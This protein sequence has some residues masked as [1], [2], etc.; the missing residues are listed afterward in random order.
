M[1]E[2]KKIILLNVGLFWLLW[3]RKLLRHEVPVT[4]MTYVTTTKDYCLYAF[5]NEK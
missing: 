4:L 2:Q 1:N 3:Y 5:G